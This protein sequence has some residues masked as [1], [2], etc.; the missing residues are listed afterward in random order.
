VSIGEALANARRRA[1]LSVT[2]VSH[3]ARIKETIITGIEGDDYSACGGDF[4][5]RGHIRRIAAAVGADPEPLI[6]Q[7]DSARLGPRALAGEATEPL[8]PLR[9]PQHRRPGPVAPA[10]MHQRRPPA[11][12]VTPTAKRRRQ[13]RPP[14]WAVALDR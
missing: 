13:R 12:P 2:Q 3:Q 6:E 7:Y 4:Y 1:G 9:M 8:T 14:A 11:E 5:A 10:G